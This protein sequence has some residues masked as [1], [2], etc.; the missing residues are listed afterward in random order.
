MRYAVIEDNIVINVVVADTPLQ[1]NW[2][3][4]ETANIGDRYINGAFEP[5]IKVEEEHG[6]D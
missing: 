4:G 6:T 5:V 1:P 2:V 3:E